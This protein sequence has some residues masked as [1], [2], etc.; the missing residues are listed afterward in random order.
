MNYGSLSGLADDDRNDLQLLYELTWSG[1][2]ADVNGTPIH[3]MV[4]YHAS[5][6]VVEP[7]CEPVGLR[8][9]LRR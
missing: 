7:A 3:L 4:P 1:Q 6:T 2:L 5:G 8:N 9:R